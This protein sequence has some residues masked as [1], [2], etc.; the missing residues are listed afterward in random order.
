MFEHGSESSR[1]LTSFD[2]G[3]P[4][5]LSVAS[6]LLVQCAWQGVDGFFQFAPGEEMGGVA[7]CVAGLRSG[8]HFEAGLQLLKDGARKE[9]DGVV[10]HFNGGTE[11]AMVIK[12]K[13]ELRHEAEGK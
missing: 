11:R 12:G 4:D 13:E 2:F 6:E 9:E 5:K 3:L 8:S 1:S 10:R 7:W